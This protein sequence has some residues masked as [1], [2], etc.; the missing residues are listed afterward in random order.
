MTNTLTTRESRDLVI[1][2][3]L[4]QNPCAVYLASLA[5]GSRRTMQQALNDI[6]AMVVRDANAFTLNWGAMR[7]QHTTAI[8]SKLAERYSAA[9][10]NKMLCAL[11]GVLKAAFNLGQLNADDY[12]RAT[13]LKAVKGN[14]VPTGRALSEKEIQALFKACDDDARDCAMFALM[15]ACGLRRAE[16]VALDLAD[17]NAS[18]GALTIRKGKGNKSRVVYVSNG[19]KKWLDAWLK[20]RGDTSGAMFC[21][22]LKSGAIETERRLSTQAVWF[23]LQQRAEKAQVKDISPHD[24]RRSFVSDLLDKGAD[25]STVQKLAGHANIATT[26]RYDK[27]GEMVKRQ[28]VQ[29]LTVPSPR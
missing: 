16:I 3:P 27:R 5:K 29:L 7:F 15:Y 18:D 26:Q 4:D 11:R 28:A 8:R 19:A 23:V 10:A 17:Y 9:T 2:Q 13:S 21:P 22:I 14:S 20:M 12:L 6:A 25:I 24:L 1:S